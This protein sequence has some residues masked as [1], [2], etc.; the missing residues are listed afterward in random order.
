MARKVS[1]THMR[2]HKNETIAILAAILKKRQKVSAIPSIAILNRDI[3]SP[4]DGI[5]LELKAGRTEQIL[6]TIEK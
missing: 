4:A 1:A 2:Y 3:N 6:G 5:E